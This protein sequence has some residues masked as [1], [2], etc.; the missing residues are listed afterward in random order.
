VIVPSV[1]LVQVFRD[2]GVT[3][4][5]HVVPLGISETY[6]YVQRPHGR[7]PFTFLTIGDRLRRKGWDLA[8]IAFH[9]AFGENPDFKLIIKTRAD[10]LP[11]TIAHPCIEILRQDMTEIEMQRLYASADAYVFPTRGEGFGLPPREAAATGLPVIATRWGGTA[12]DLTAWG[13]PLRYTL[14]PAWQD[15]EKLRG[16]GDWAL[17]D[18]DHLAEQMKY[19]SSGNPMIAHMGQESARRV[20]R[21]Y[22]WQ[23][24]SD[25]ML[26]VWTEQQNAIKVAKE[27]V[28]GN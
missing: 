20:R 16:V 11:I 7:K 18:I 19:V 2:C 14:V 24:W 27:V 6:Q 22:D 9:K 28:Y 8:V 15:N 23:R 13:Y 21:L 26:K 10:G 1:W 5:I 3:V 17:P 4:P 25:G 12:D